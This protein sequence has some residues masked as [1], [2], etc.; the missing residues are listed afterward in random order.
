MKGRASTDAPNR[1]AQSVTGTD[2]RHVVRWS[3]LGPYTS[4]F[5]V[6]SPLHLLTAAFGSAPRRR[7]PSVREDLTRTIVDRSR[8]WRAAWAGNRPGPEPR[9]KGR[10]IDSLAI[11]S[12][13]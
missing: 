11:V 7:E 6:R 12:S 4:P 5:W 2:L 8:S 9:D 3:S 1:P 13:R 10:P